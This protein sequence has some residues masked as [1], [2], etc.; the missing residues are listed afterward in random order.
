MTNPKPIPTA[1]LTILQ[2]E[3]ISLQSEGV[4]DI[5]LPPDA[6]R[7]A[8]DTLRLAQIGVNGGEVW[9]KNG[10]RFAPTYDIWHVEKSDYSSHEEYLQASLDIAELN[11]GRYL[12]APESIFIVLGL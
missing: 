8:I 11:V 9:A 4:V 10:A 3:G 7:R 1:F 5:A 6:A 12:D 2:K